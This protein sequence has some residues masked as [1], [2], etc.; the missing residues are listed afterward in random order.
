MVRNRFWILRVFAGL[1][2]AAGLACFIVNLFMT[3]RAAE[4]RVPELA[5]AAA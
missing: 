3:Y 2:M 1:T 5:P 4:E